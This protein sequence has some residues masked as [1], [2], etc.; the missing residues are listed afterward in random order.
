MCSSPLL[1]LLLCGPISPPLEFS[2]PTC[3]L[4]HHPIPAQSLNLSSD[5]HLGCRITYNNRIWLTQPNMKLFLIIYLFL[6]Y[7][8]NNESRC[9][10]A[11]Y[12]YIYILYTCIYIYFRLSQEVTNNETKII[13]FSYKPLTS[14]YAGLPPRQKFIFPNFGTWCNI[15]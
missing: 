10:S 13:R 12:V 15:L 3:S 4:L 7:I 8:V 1:P 14:C 2:L 9:L 11:Y 5:Q 6:V